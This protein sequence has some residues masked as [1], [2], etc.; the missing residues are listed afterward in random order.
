MRDPAL[1][2]LGNS[3]KH[4]KKRRL[5]VTVLANDADSVA[6]CHAQRHIFKNDLGGIFE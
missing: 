5:A 1:I 4:R 2:G 3:G 6:F